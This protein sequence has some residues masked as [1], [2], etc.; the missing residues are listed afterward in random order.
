MN[1]ALLASHYSIDLEKVQKL[2]NPFARFT[3][4]P[5]IAPLTNPDAPNGNDRRLS[6]SRKNT[7]VADA[8]DL[9]TLVQGPLS[10]INDTKGSESMP[11]DKR[12]ADFGTYLYH[13]L[14]TIG[15]CLRGPKAA[16]NTNSCP[17]DVR[18]ISS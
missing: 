10:E 8:N 6:S 1:H 17:T 4:L 15:E 3:P 2:A 16:N 5:N 7:Q 11:Q 13:I 12:W 9:L 18:P 14:S